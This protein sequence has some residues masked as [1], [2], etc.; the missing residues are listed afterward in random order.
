MSRRGDG[1]LRLVAVHLPEGG[2]RVEVDGELRIGPSSAVLLRPTGAASVTDMRAGNV[3]VTLH[4][5][6]GRAV[7]ARVAL[8]AVEQRP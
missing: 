4:D 7:K 2:L 8:L 6:D 5:D 3:Y 1:P